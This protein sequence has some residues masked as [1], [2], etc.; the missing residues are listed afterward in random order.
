MGNKSDLNHKREVSFEQASKLA[1][2]LKI[3]LLEI[4]A[5]NSVNIDSAFEMLIQEILDSFKPTHKSTTIEEE[6][7]KSA[8]QLHDNALK[9][10]QKYIKC[11][12]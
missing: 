6:N 11:C 10:H 9:K 4:S 5:K 12:K 8:I 2:E 3:P 1:A 7:E